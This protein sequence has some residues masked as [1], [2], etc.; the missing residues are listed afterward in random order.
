MA[1]G[2][3]PLATSVASV[4]YTDLN[5]LVYNKLNPV[6]M[7]VLYLAV[8]N[9]NVA[10][11][12]TVYSSNTPHRHARWNFGTYKGRLLY[13]PNKKKKKEN[14]SYFTRLSFPMFRG[15]STLQISFFPF[16]SQINYIIDHRN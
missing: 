12:I 5:W 3:N 15:I 14:Q 8:G 16:K 13:L 2:V 7:F 11:R 4:I 9:M 10:H 1:T 6:I